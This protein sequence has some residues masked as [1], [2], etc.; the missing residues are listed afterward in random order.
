MWYWNESYLTQLYVVG[1][2][3][4]AE[5]TLSTLV[6]SLKTFDTA[7]TTAASQSG[8][9]MVS[10]NENIKMAGTMLSILPLLIMYF[11]LQR[12]FVESV[13]RTG[14]ML[15]NQVIIKMHVGKC[16]FLRCHRRKSLRGTW[17]FLPTRLFLPTR[18]DV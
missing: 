8:G 10:I 16:D 17:V 11:V 13:D 3:G 6:V 1:V 5:S 14:N 12:Q 9:T 4:G 18:N 15:Y 2:T 7:Y